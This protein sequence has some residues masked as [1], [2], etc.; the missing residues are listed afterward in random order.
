MTGNAYKA[1][2]PSA[3]LTKFNDFNHFIALS[4]VTLTNDLTN[5]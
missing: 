3:N 1:D 4:K 2:I 5:A